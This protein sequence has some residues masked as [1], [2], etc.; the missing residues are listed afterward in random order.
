MTR[1]PDPSAVS[2]APPHP[3]VSVLVV[4]D[5]PA[6][7]RSVTR[8]LQPRGFSVIAASSAAEAL[9]ALKRDDTIDVVL[10]DVVMPGVSGLDLLRTIREANLAVQVVMMTAFADIGVAVTAVKNGAHDFLTKPFPSPDALA[11]SIQK[12][13][14]HN[15]LL[16]RSRHLEQLL[17]ER[18]RESDAGIIGNA[19]PMRSLYR[20][21]DALARSAATVV[22]QG[23]S[24]TGKEL[25]ARAIHRRSPRSE[26]P[27]VP[28]NC[29]A[30]PET[31]VE[32]ELF[33]YVRGAFTGA[34]EHRKGLFE[35]AHQ[36]TLLL[37]E[38]GDLSLR[39][40]VKL[41]RALQ[42]GEIKRI[43]ATET[44]RVDVRVIA[45]TH[46]DL[47]DAMRTGRFREDLFYRLNVVPLFLPALRE[48]KSDIPLLARHFLTRYAARAAHPVTG[49]SAEA[50]AALQRYDW[51]GNVRELENA[52]ERAVVVTRDPEIQL[53]DLP[54]ALCPPAGHPQSAAVR[55]ALFYAPLF[56]RPFA[57][58]K[59]AATTQFAQAYTQALLA[60]TQ[61]NVSRAAEL[62]GLNR[63][64]FRRL[65][66]QLQA[67]SDASKT[68]KK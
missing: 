35:A 18:E 56:E 61:G 45:A 30:I 20:F 38:I 6:S 23:E 26:H 48:R 1:A 29:A 67:A 66:R 13:A 22:I 62:A 68:T 19:A 58:A 5:D 39:V 33:G 60:R 55:T 28:V 51:P 36:G 12:A 57:Q 47:Q 8:I 41:L 63:S 27:F 9:I 37:D 2:A 64:N 40:Q 44:T 43:G 10:L 31:L 46:M 3:A 42:D 54:A 17:R 14:E 7:V 65:L 34:R 25:V 24:G 16:T 52:I 15:R 32:A 49:F 50:L 11:L 53:R 21:I 59:Q 4:D